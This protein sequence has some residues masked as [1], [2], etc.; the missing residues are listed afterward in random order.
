MKNHTNQPAKLLDIDW[1]SWQAVDTAT[2]TFVVRQKQILL[3]RKKR[4]LG[5]GKINGPGGRLE[6]NESILECAI[7]ETQEELC[8]TPIDP[9]KFGEL[10]FQFVDG[11]SIHVHVFRATGC[12]GTPAETDE[13]VPIWA[14]LDT[15]P[16]DEMWE[17]DEI[18]LPHLIAGR[19]FHGRF[20]FDS[21]KMLDHALE[22]IST[23]QYS[24][25]KADG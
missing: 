15:V 18:W 9:Q 22:L 2:L 19:S 8:V 14:S 7:R 11:Y 13:A 1:A 16:Y 6:G 17:D 21:D 10:Q 3:I 5:A 23:P 25:V 12:H 4:G 20:I 24:N